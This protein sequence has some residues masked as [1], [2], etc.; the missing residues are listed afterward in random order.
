MNNDTFSVNESRHAGHV[1]DTS[2]G[3]N[4]LHMKWINYYEVIIH[5]VCTSSPKVK[6]KT[7]TSLELDEF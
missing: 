7:Y 4:T 3:S 2:L 5:Y 6:C 1:M